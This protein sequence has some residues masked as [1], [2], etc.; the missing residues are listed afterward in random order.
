MLPLAD[1]EDQVIARMNVRTT[2]ESTT[3]PHLPMRPFTPEEQKHEFYDMDA[4]KA[5]WLLHRANRDGMQH[6]SRARAISVI[7]RKLRNQ[8]L[9]PTSGN[10]SFHLFREIDLLSVTA[11][12]SIFWDFEKKHGPTRRYGTIYTNWEA[13]NNSTLKSW[14]RLDEK[15]ELGCGQAMLRNKGQV[16]VMAR[17]PCLVE[18]QESEECDGIKITCGLMTLNCK[19][20]PRFAPPPPEHEDSPEDQEERMAAAARDEAFAWTLAKEMADRGCNMDKH[21][22]HQL[23]RRYGKEYLHY[24]TDSE[25]EESEVEEKADSDA[26]AG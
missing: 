23:A 11:C 22:Y 16:L 17:L 4:G 14:F 19:G 21:W 3:S 24:M 5:N 15:R 9:T 7:K 10:P 12:K 26:S 13:T 2:S 6:S 18:H 25:E 20:V 8:L 1:S